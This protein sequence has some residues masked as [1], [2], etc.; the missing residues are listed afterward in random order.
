LIE[1]AC[2]EYN[3]LRRRGGG[4]CT[5]DLQC[6]AKL[7]FYS[8]S[9]PSTPSSAMSNSSTLPSRVFSLS[10]LL[11]LV[12]FFRLFLPELLS[13]VRGGASL[14]HRAIASARSVPMGYS[15]AS[16]GVQ[17]LGVAESGESLSVAVPAG[18]GAAWACSVIRA[19]EVGD[20]AA[21]ASRAASAL[22][23][24]RKRCSRART[25]RWKDASSTTRSS[26]SA[27]R[28]ASCFCRSRRCSFVSALFRPLSPPPPAAL[29][30]FLVSAPLALP[31][32]PCPFP[33]PPAYPP[34]LAGRHKRSHD[35]TRPIQFP[36]RRSTSTQSLLA[37]LLA[38]RKMG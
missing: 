17:R 19:G 3:A 22:S 32:P 26:A 14:T 15:F 34:S 12:P 4:Y 23:S 10:A 21:D 11:F 7:G 24:S 18:G 29:P 35:P 8:S 38:A 25:A 16:D 9:S 37:G 31:L 13:L 27:S 33:L 20:D 5:L 30:P 1:C 36:P 6:A 28:M 2:Q